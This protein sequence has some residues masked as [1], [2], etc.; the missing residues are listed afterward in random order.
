MK[1]RTILSVTGLSIRFPGAP[2]FIAVADISF[3]VKE[4]RTLAI[5][6]ESGSGK[7]LT[8]LAL[9]GLLPRNAKVTGQMMLHSNDTGIALNELRSVSDWNRIRGRE[10]GMVFQEPMSAL[11]PV[12]KIGRQLQE[13]I[14][15]HQTVSRQTARRQAIEW[16]GKVKLPDA[17]KIYDRYPHQL[18]GGQ[19]QR[20]MIAMAMCNRPKLL[21]ADEPTT[22]LDVTVQMEVIA[23]MQELQQQ[24]GTAMIFITHDLVL[25]AEIAD[26]LLVMYKGKS[27]EY[28]S[29]EK[30]FYH[31]SHPYTQA[32]I[33]CKPSP[34]QKGRLLPTVGDFMDMPNAAAAAP[35]RQYSSVWQP[36]ADEE[37]PL[38]QVKHLSVRFPETTGW[39]GKVQSYYKAVDDVSF[40]LYTGEVLGLVGESGCGKST[41]SK[42]I[43]GLTPIHEGQVLFAGRDLA[44][45]SGAEWREVRKDIQMI[46]QDPFSSLNPR[47]TVGPM[48]AEPLKAHR[49]VPDGELYKEVKRLLDMVHLPADSMH[50]YPHQ[51]SG[52][53]R[54]R[55]GIARALALRPKLLICDESVSAL[56]VSV[57]AQVLNLLKEL[58]SDFHLS[59]LFIS[60][61]LA[62]V[63]YISDRVL[64]MQAGAIVESGDAADV[65]E[66]PG[67]AYTRRLIASVPG[68]KR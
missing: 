59:Y 27:V 9:M 53:Q 64:V 31:P 18:S 45:C 50:R 1:D 48:L 36:A 55:I 62:V 38:L 19:K 65:L 51:F 6:G 14:L 10:T 28:G 63:H 29:A 54:Q 17:E 52:G 68:A 57:Q 25:A 60:H 35:A 34:D 44:R 20:V 37:K 7:S 11:N 61:D 43:L 42:S 49:I 22:A 41:L 24:T 40:S 47:M 32:L 30:L 4:G 21:I 56:D 58:Q 23:L 2:E 67:H 15:V 66:R 46:F 8:A 12:M 33:A 5:V 26:E 39:L 13:A 16:L 3:L